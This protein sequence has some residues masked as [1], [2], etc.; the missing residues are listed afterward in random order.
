MGQCSKV[1]IVDA[2]SAVRE[3]IAALLDTAGIASRAFA[4]ID[5]MLEAFDA[6]D[7]GCVT[8]DLGRTG[9]GLQMV[10]LLR[11]LGHC[12]PAILFSAR[13][14]AEKKRL[15]E[16]AGAAALLAKPADPGEF[17][18]IVRRLLAS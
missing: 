8:A 17:V 5:A 1:Y 16:L 4:S 6:S 15:V 11:K 12:T 3:S 9:A 13:L 18:Q 10:G 7:A 2:D 14:T